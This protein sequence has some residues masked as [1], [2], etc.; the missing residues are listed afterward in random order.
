MP[1]I[2]TS[3]Q[4]KHRQPRA[5]PREIAVPNLTKPVTVGKPRK[6][7]IVV[8]AGLLVERQVRTRRASAASGCAADVLA[9]TGQEGARHQSPTCDELRHRLF[10]A[11]SFHSCNTKDAGAR[12]RRER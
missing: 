6:N 5:L 2:D 11:V 9:R 12:R 1:A 10:E 8:G 3:L 4:A 7:I